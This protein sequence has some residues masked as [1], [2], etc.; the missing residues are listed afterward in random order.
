M[1]NHPLY[2]V[3][4][5]TQKMNKLSVFNRLLLCTQ[6]KNICPAYNFFHSFTSFNVL[7]WIDN[8]TQHYCLLASEAAS[9]FFA[10]RLH[11]ISFFNKV[12]VIPFCTIH[13]IHSFTSFYLL[14]ITHRSFHPFSII[15]TAAVHIQC[16]VTAEFWK[17][18]RMS[19][20]RKKHVL[21]WNG[22]F[23]FC[24]HHFFANQEEIFEKFKE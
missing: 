23:F 21:K 3:C 13:F 11:F 17:R 9:A 1:N 12:V 24:T 4:M 10:V 15:I 22:S 7:K 2:Y 8:G 6:K 5:F 19:N 16:I 20:E 14:F 18:N